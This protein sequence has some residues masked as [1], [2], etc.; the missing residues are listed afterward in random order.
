MEPLVTVVTVAF[1]SEKTIEKTI[2]SVLGQTYPRIEYLII[3]GMSSDKT[4]ELC[5]GYEKQA[6]ERGYLYRIVSEKDKGI[7]DAMN[8]G[9]AMAKGKYWALSTATTGMKRMRCLFP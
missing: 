9:I 7:Y 2:K 6:L 4:V 5:K 8:K 1:N 3:D